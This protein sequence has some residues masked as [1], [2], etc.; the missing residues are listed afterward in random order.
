MHPNNVASD[1]TETNPLSRLLE[2]IRAVHEDWQ[3]RGAD[4]LDDS[5]A[6]NKV[7]EA[8]I[9]VEVARLFSEDD[10]RLLE[11]ISILVGEHATDDETDETAGPSAPDGSAFA[12]AQRHHPGKVGGWKREYVG[13]VA[14]QREFGSLGTFLAFRRAE[15]SG[16]VRIAG[17]RSR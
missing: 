10:A 2:A 9:G 12:R 7:A 4:V 14:L 15:A 17:R 8:E 5:T 3:R 11:E 6:N 1:S 16:R 13:S